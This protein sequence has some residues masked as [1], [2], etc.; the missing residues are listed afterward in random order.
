[1]TFLSHGY[2]S[3]NDKTEN[4]KKNVALGLYRMEVIKD[5]DDTYQVIE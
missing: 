3:S 5:T 4:K 1:M 2:D